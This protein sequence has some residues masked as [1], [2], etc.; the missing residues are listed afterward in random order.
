MK[1]KKLIYNLCL[2][3]TAGIFIVSIIITILNNILA[4]DTGIA[5]IFIVILL[6]FVLSVFLNYEKSADSEKLKNHYSDPIGD[7]KLDWICTDRGIVNEI[8][9]WSGIQM[10]EV[11]EYPTIVYTQ[12]EGYGQKVKLTVEFARRRIG[13]PSRISQ[14]TLLED[15][16][17]SFFHQ[18]I[19]MYSPFF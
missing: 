9:K 3:F 5:M 8:L 7:N 16:S 2:I 18:I 10:P 12:V 1:K 14:N 19:V 15:S 17:Y 13:P 4:K 6:C 11:P